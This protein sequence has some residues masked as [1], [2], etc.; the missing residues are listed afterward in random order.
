MVVSVCYINVT[1]IKTM[2]ISL[3]KFT[4]ELKRNKSCPDNNEPKNNNYSVQPADLNT[5][6]F[7]SHELKGILGSTVMC[8]YAIR[9]GLLGMLNF[10]QRA[11]IEATIRNLRRLES[12]IKDFLDLSRIEDGQLKIRSVKFNVNNDVIKEVEDAF[13]SEIYERRML[14]ENNIS[15]DL[16]INTDRNLLL[17]V[18]NNLV[19]NAVKYG[20]PGGKIII[21]SEDLK[22]KIRFSVYND[23]IPVS[24]DE[25]EKLFKKF[26][27]LESE[28][29]K[30][31]KG[32][33]L[34]LFITKNIVN[35]LGGDIWVKPGEKGNTFIFEIGRN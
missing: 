22:N 30:K 32:T 6:E 4:I 33:G 1:N 25:K 18:F 28:H 34:G 14:L 15:Q 5:V 24:A 29:N 7:V 27:R 26:S 12:T 31:I 10:K 20:S 16:V 3:G 2:R 8:V 9:D 19:S 11:S 21:N 17:T 35:A 13:I 23:G